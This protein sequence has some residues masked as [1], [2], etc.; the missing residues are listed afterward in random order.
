MTEP[1][2]IDGLVSRLQG[3]P[4]SVK[5]D[6]AMPVLDDV[7]NAYR[8][9]D[10]QQR[11]ALRAVV[12]KTPLACAPLLEQYLTWVATER[13]QHGFSRVLE[14]AMTAVSITGGFSD[15]RDTLLWLDALWTTAEQHGIDPR[16]FFERCA[17]LSDTEETR[18]PIF[19]SSTKG[20]ILLLLQYSPTTGRPRS[21]D[22]IGPTSSDPT[23]STMT[24]PRQKLWWKFW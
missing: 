20:L 13:G 5:A 11:T 7:C 15:S 17:E 6:E 3:W 9:A 8:T 12:R 14:A 2:D 10:D 1:L 22:G 23:E 18:H 24:E 21:G 19:G 16:P 4:D